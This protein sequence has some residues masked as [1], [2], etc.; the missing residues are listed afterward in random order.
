[1]GL[2]Q[3]TTLDLAGCTALDWALDTALVW[4]SETPDGTPGAMRHWA[5]NL[6]SLRAL[7]HP[8]G[9]VSSLSRPACTLWGE[10]CV[11]FPD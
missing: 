4:A 3:L 6:P 8:T 9:A 2:E 11:E 7:V 5:L 10:S 1:V